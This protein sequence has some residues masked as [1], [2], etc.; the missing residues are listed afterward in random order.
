M[1]LEKSSNYLCFMSKLELIRYFYDECHFDFSEI[2][3][4]LNGHEEII[5]MYF[6]SLILKQKE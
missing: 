1:N 5:Q 6:T 4:I 2:S 3:W